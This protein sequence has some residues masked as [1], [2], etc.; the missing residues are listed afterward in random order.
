VYLARDPKHDR[1]VA[2]KVL[3][4]ELAV[5][6]GAERFLREIQIMARLAHPHILPL[7]D[8]GAANGVLYLVAPYIAGESLRDR[9]AREGRLGVEEALE[10]TREVASALDYAHRHGVVHRDIKPAN[11]LLQDGRAVVADFG[12][13]LALSASGG[14]RVTAT[15]L[16]PGT[17]SYMSPEQAAGES[18]VDARSDVYSLGCV[19]YE[20]LT[21]QPPHAGPDARAVLARVLSEPARPAGA[22]RAEVPPHVEGALTRALAKAPAERFPTAAELARALSG[23]SMAPRVP[24][25]DEAHAPAG[26]A[27]T[28]L[29]IRIAG[30]LALATL[31]LFTA[32]YVALYALGIVPRASLLASGVVAP[33]ERVLITDFHVS[34]ADST[35][36]RPFGAAVRT[37]L[38][39]SQELTIVAPEAVASALERMRRPRNALVDLSTARDIALR[40]GVRAIVDGH[41]VRTGRTFAVGLR[42]VAADSGKELVTLQAVVDGVD[43]IL[44][45]LDQL[46]RQLRQRIGESLERVRATP[47]LPQLTTQSLEALRLYDEHLRVRDQRAALSLLIAAVKADSEFAEGWRRIHVLRGNLGLGGPE[48][49]AAITKA[50]EYSS[51]LPDR[52]RIPI[53][54]QYHNARGDRAQAIELF[55][56]GLDLGDTSNSPVNL[57]DLVESRREF[58]R[59]EAL[60]RLVLRRAVAPG[61]GTFANLAGR[62]MQQGRLREAAAT[63]DSGLLRSPNAWPLQR[64]RIRLLYLSDSLDAYARVLDSVRALP[65]LTKRRSATSQRRDLALLRG[66][67]AEWKRLWLDA[68]SLDSAGGVALLPVS[69][70]WG[71]AQADLF[72]RGDTGGAVTRLSRAVEERMMRLGRGDHCCVAR[73]Y[74]LWGAFL[75]IAGHT[76]QALRYR[77]RYDSMVDPAR[78]PLNEPWVHRLLAQVALAK[79]RWQ[80]ALEEVRRGDMYPDGPAGACEICLYQSLGDAFDR[81]GMP[82]SAIVMYER[83]VA[84]PYRDRLTEDALHLARI[85]QR[86]GSL[87]ESRGDRQRALHYYSQY[88]ELWKNADPEL[89]PRVMDA[90]QRVTRLQ[91]PSR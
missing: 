51:K 31:A 15:G 18:G 4:P 49:L 5:S 29:R 10:I 63:L 66:Q 12:V 57:A 33:Q 78:R 43:E 27:G 83:Y 88:V 72:V 86:L 82:D 26:V 55:Q 61:P 16:S 59:A 20:M 28:W 9:L 11:I 22:L 37:A 53:A 30:A 50:Y 3:R 17:P 13:A 90:R 84:T 65:D 80:E 76:D 54:A 48:W 45:T 58:E 2:V 71:V 35:F 38:A 85:L 77:T 56:R 7:I 24:G 70:V 52:E 40:E 8:S 68:R 69:D 79:G 46:T 75:A 41:V 32:V 62:L 19:L 23:V 39:Q 14:E 21:G 64:E 91:R 67:L 34:G 6:L 36:G 25:L 47:P 42:L 44:P 60:D 87:H 81:G 1:H 89:Q 74:L 73:G